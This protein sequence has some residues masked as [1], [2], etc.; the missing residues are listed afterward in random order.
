[1]LPNASLSSIV[2]EEI[3]LEGLEGSTLDTLWNHIAIRLR[4]PMPL[5]RK[6]MESI[7]LQIL[8]ISEFEFFLLPNDRKPFAH[9]NRVGKLDPETGIALQPSEYP[10]HRFRYR[11][12]ETNGIR[13]SCEDYDTRTPITREE[14]SKIPCAD[15]EQRYNRKL[16]IVASQRMRESYL[17]D[18]NCTAELSGMQYCMLEWIGR[19]R[20]NGE[21]SHGKHSLI[22]VTGD[23][24]A[25]FY[26]RKALTS[27][28]LITRQN[29][30]IRIDNVSIQ[31]L[32]FHLP[33]YYSEMKSK[34]LLIVELVVKELKSRKNYIAD[35]EEIKLMMLKKSEAGKIFRTPEFQRYIKTDETVP[36]RTLYP[37]TPPSSWYSKRGEEKQVRVM[38]LIDPEA[39]VYDLWNR[40][41]PEE[42]GAADT[43][44]GFLCSADSSMLYVDLP[45]LQVAYNAIANH[46]G[47]GIAQSELAVALGLDRLNVRGVVKNLT[48]LKAIEGL[49]FDEGRQRTTKFFIPGSSRRT[50]VFEKEMSQYVSNQLNV[51]ESQRQST[52]GSKSDPEL[53]GNETL[54]TDDSRNICD[55]EADTSLSV[56]ADSDVRKQTHAFDST[57]HDNIHTDV[58]LSDKL[59]LR[60]NPTG[61]SYVMK[62]R[63]ISELMLRRC[64]F[65]IELVKREVAI[66]PRTI[67]KRLKFAEN[68][69]GN[70]HQVCNKSLMRLIYRLAADKMILIANVTM[71]LE[72]R[73]FH[74]VFICDPKITVEHAGLQSKLAMAKARIVLQTQPAVPADLAQPLSALQSHGYPG[75]LPKCMRMRLFHE[76]V[77]YLVHD[78]QRDAR[79]LCITE[80]TA[81][82]VTGLDALELSPIYSDTNDWKMF[83]PPLNPYDGGYDSGWVMLTDV[84]VRMPLVVFCSICTFSFYTKDLDHYLDHPVRRYYL[85]KQLPETIR[86]QLLKKRR[87]VQAVLEI[88]KLL[89]YA[90][91]LQM[92]PQLRNTRDQTYVYV[93]RYACMLDTSESKDGY[94]EIENRNYPLLPFCFEQ[95]TDVQGFWDKLL[96]VATGTR[97]NIRNTAIG[98]EVLIQQLHT[99]PAMVEALRVQSELSA[100]LNDR[101][102]RLPPG[103]GKGAAGFDTAMF[104][105]IK[106][107]WSKTLNFAPH[108][109][110]HR[111]KIVRKSIKIKK[112]YASGNGPRSGASAVSNGG[113]LT[114]RMGTGTSG[115]PATASTVKRG[116]G[117]RQ[118][119]KRIIK[120]RKPMRRIWRQG[121]DEV[122]LRAL[123]QMNKLRVKWTHA[124]DQILVICR[125]AQLYLYG[126]TQ[127]ITCPINSA[128]FRDVLHWANARSTCKTSR[129]CQ[130]RVLYMTKKLHGVADLVRTCLEET[131]LNATVTERYGPGFVQKL[132]EQFQEPED[133]MVASCIHFVQLVHLIR[134]TCS[135]LLRGTG[136]SNSTPRIHSRPEASHRAYHRLPSTLDELYRRYS[137]TETNNSSKHL[138]YAANPSTIQELQMYKLTILMHSSVVNG[139][140]HAE[141]PLQR[142]YREFSEHVLAGAMRLMRN[143]HLVSLNQRVKG[144]GTKLLVTSTAVTGDRELFHVSI[145]YQQQLITSLPFDLFQPMFGQYV[146]LLDRKRYD[147]MHACEDD[148]KG[149]VLLISELIAM[150]RV[151]MCIDQAANYIEMKAGSKE[152]VPNY[153]DMLAP[154]AGPE[155]DAFSDDAPKR[156]RETKS[157]KS[158]VKAAIVTPTRTPTG[159]G[160]SVPKK[161]RF[162]PAKDVT[163]HYV[164]HPV[165]RLYKVPIEYFHF[166]CLLVHLQTTDRRLIVQMFKIDETQ[167]TSCSLENCVGA[168]STSAASSGDLVSRCLELM[169]GHR[170]QLVRIRQ[171]GVERSQRKNRI[172]SAMIF[173]IREENILLFFGKY[174]T[175]FQQRWSAGHRREVNRQSQVSQALV[176]GTVDMAELIEDCLWFDDESPE[177]NW[178]D[179]YEVS[180]TIEDEDPI[181]GET[182]DEPS[183]DAEISTLS[184]KVFKL[185]NFYEVMSMK[186]HI[187]LKTTPLSRYTEQDLADRETYGQWNVPRCFLSDGVKRRRDVLIKVASDAIWP[188]MQQLGPLI[189]EAMPLIE[190]NSHA[191]ALL[192]Y[193]EHKS[194][195]GATACELAKSFPNHEQLKQHLQTLVSLKLLLRTGFRSVTYVHWHF[196]PDW[197]TK[198]LIPETDQ[199]AIEQPSSAQSAAVEQPGGSR[200]RRDKRKNPTPLGDEE[201]ITVKKRKSNYS[202]QTTKSRSID[203]R[204]E[205]QPTDEQPEK[206]RDAKKYK[207][208]QLAM[209]PWISIEGKINKRVL[210]RW[211]S[212]VLLYCVA[213]P[214]VLMSVLNV[215]FNMLSPFHLR[216]LL[217]I[218][219]EYGCVS[220]HSMECQLKKTIFSVFK[221]IGIVPPTEFAPDEKTFVESA[222]DALSTL[223]LCIGENRKYAQDFYD[224]SRKHMVT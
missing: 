207:F 52:S 217:E 104:M 224:G 110:K 148:A 129:A 56:T 87:Y 17:I 114:L 98:R 210:Y 120:P 112:L 76:Y 85:L 60:K 24:S 61:T 57:L 47:V 74:L 117:R 128:T 118:I 2:K 41:G 3:G 180:N 39:E 25:L 159:K 212:S 205:N 201:D 111:L 206:Q 4:M 139:R 222:P 152:A 213:H 182:G 144:V 179:R 19:S 108:I 10:G 86:M 83:I 177:Y 12:V 107:N 136:T 16:V 44:E 73:E 13:G 9:F 70:L 132:R 14:L 100:P 80:L 59:H 51:I 197:L 34:Q 50:Q 171:H 88:V 106:S 131:K 214:G 138:N 91:L 172:D 45:L 208:M 157:L 82:D 35:Y 43:K 223:S 54:A 92:G 200:T 186:M 221:P 115:F 22:E 26:N 146:Q 36:Y 21:T 134:Q 113:R 97:L 38:R 28:K 65:I 189:K 101:P 15:A 165:E 153:A 135:K 42:G 33:R 103:D 164:M 188:D 125:V 133:Y 53:T 93:N 5:P 137:V 202:E 99:K 161:L 27:A 23:S 181:D 64:N 66:E 48:K 20:F 150:D 155:K 211:L 216:Q 109:D 141:E 160:R 123:K 95:M 170:E 204:T 130:R 168:S 105:H 195:F 162:S 78:Q 18:S 178:L 219:Q 30:S 89:C 37:N 184:E 158:S 151:E 46:E 90:G 29:L 72:D 11:L 203:T 71:K 67:L 77:F 145:H 193:I 142:V 84:F 31:G 63:S 116:S 121:Y 173:D 198:A 174:I 176:K 94:Y 126:P 58:I 79:E 40:D 215:R 32:V 166:F 194:R 68:A 102:E 196:A 122:D 147:E 1:M 149:L 163:F 220:L 191:S 8:P 81:I 192:A 190:R 199:K 55:S 143:F 209:A 62:S 127:S 175:Q 183:T 96:D 7:W 69:K 6:L 49:S 187:R 75:S 218:L 169:R 154:L 167:P 119:K 124:E 140:S 156:T 185:H